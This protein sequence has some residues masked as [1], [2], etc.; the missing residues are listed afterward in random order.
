MGSI[1]ET[2]IDTVCSGL[3]VPGRRC[4]IFF[5]V[6]ENVIVVCTVGSKIATRAK[7]GRMLKGVMLPA[8]VILQHL[9]LDPFVV[10]HVAAAASTPV[11]MES[12]PAC[13]VY[14]TRRLR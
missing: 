8:Y 3:R 14:C 4:V 9:Q 13:N 10:T 2:R 11:V 1:D 6:L 12:I 5:C 7:G